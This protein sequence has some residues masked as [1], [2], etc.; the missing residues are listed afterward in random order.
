MYTMNELEDEEQHE[1]EQLEDEQLEDE[2]HTHLIFSWAA[3]I[4]LVLLI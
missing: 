1:Q 2:E 4:L 3:A